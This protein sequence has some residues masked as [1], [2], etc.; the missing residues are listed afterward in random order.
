MAPDVSFQKLGHEAVHCASGRAH[1]LQNFGAIALFGESANQSFNLPLNTLG[2]ENEIL[3]VF[4]CV[5]HFDVAYHTGYGMPY[6]FWIRGLK[7]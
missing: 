3:L 5:A 6:L 7:K 4:D 1:H 2:P